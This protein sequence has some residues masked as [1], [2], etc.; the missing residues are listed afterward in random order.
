MIDYRLVALL[1]RTLGI[2][3]SDDLHVDQGEKTMFRRKQEYQ[4]YCVVV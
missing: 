1:P 3:H 2:G 4:D